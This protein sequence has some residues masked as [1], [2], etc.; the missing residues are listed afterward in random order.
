MKAIP[1]FYVEKG[2]PFQKGKRI[3]LD[4]KETILGRYHSGNRTSVQFYSEFVSRRHLSVRIEG[5][6]A[7]VTDLGSKHGTKVE[8][9]ALTPHKPYLLRNSDI[10][11]LANGIVV[12]HFAVSVPEETLDLDPSFMNTDVV[13]AVPPF[14]L[15]YAR[16]SCRIAQETVSLSEK[17]WNLLVLLYE[18]A[19]TLVPNEEI[20]RQVWPERYSL[21]QDSSAVS[22]VEINSLVYRVRRKIKDSVEVKN[23]RGK[24]FYLVFGNK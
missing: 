16:R 14:T 4:K 22:L 17:E 1:C 19:N 24:G 3:P 2:E 23:I 7:F 8:E 6:Q 9:K 10:I 5:D 15:D 12:L 13:Q 18:K 21:Y 20:I 11:R